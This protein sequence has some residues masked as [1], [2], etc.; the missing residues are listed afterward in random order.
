[1]SIVLVIAVLAL[2]Y[3]AWLHRGKAVPGAS[4]LDEVFDRVHDSVPLVRDGD[5]DRADDPRAQTH[6]RSL[7]DRPSRG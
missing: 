3:A 2:A 5:L 6:E 1:M 4:W 7:D